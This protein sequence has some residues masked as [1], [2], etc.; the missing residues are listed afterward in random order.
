M[1]IFMLSTF[2]FILQF[3]AIAHSSVNSEGKFQLSKFNKLWDS[4]VKI[5]KSPMKLSQ[6]EV[7]LKKL[8]KEELALKHLKNEGKDVKDLEAST[9]RHLAE[10]LQQYQLGEQFDD[11]KMEYEKTFSD[12]QLENI[13]NSVQFESE[14]NDNELHSLYKE[15]MYL[16]D[17]INNYQKLLTKAEKTVKNDIKSP[18]YKD[19]AAKHSK[20]LT[21]LRIKL[22]EEHDDI[23]IRI[24]QVKKKVNMNEA[25][26][27]DKRVVDLWNKAKSTKYFSNEELKSIKNELRYFQTGIDKLIFWQ[28]ESTNLHNRIH[29]QGERL[30]EEYNHAKLKL[31]EYQRHVT[32]YHATMVNRISPKLEL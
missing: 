22:K 5:I 6:L 20:R 11:L 17:A 10:I 7:S 31:E 13:W 18:S 8:D 24:Q 9:Q 25:S 14:I 12:D 29:N 19:E 15:L 16:Q 4:A 1:H 3:F 23:A 27:I 32:K 2:G 21:E 28:N 30:S 26:I